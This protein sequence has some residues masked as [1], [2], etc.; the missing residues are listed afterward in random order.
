MLLRWLGLS[1]TAFSLSGHR[2]RAGNVSGGRALELVGQMRWATRDRMSQWCLHGWLGKMLGHLWNKSFSYKSS[3][4]IDSCRGRSSSVGKASW[5]KVPPRGATQLMWVHIPGRCI[6]VWGKIL[7]TPSVGVWGETHVC[8]NKCWN[9]AR[10]K[11][12]DSS[13]LILSWH[14]HSSELEKL[15]D[16]FSL[17]ALSLSKELLGWVPLSQFS[18]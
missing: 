6:G 18:W 12:I 3:S 8:R 7:A 9:W 15:P 2:S 16:L 4:K 1:I 10:R 14:Y 5:I 17:K 13:L 11:K